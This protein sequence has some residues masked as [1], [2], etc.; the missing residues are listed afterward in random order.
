ME[1]IQLIF[2]VLFFAALAAFLLWK[3]RS[4]VLEWLIFPVVY[5]AM[6]RSLWGIRAMDSLAARM[7]PVLR[8]IGILAVIIGFIGMGLISYQLVK[9]LSDILFQKVSGSTVG[10][11]Q[12]FAQ[13]V[14]GTIFVPFIYFIVSIF[15]I[16]VLHE[17]AHGVM[18]RA[19]NCKVKSS[20]F[21]FFGILIPVIPAAFVEPSDKE[22]RRRPVM[23]QLSVLSAGAVT[24]VLFAAMVLLLLIY[25]IEPATKSLI[26]PLGVEVVKVE[27]GSPAF[28]S[29]LKPGELI[30][31]LNGAPVLDSKAMIGILKSMKPGDMLSIAASTT[32]HAAVL[33]ENPSKKGAP[34]LGFQVTNK[35]IVSESASQRYGQVFVEGFLWLSGLLFWVFNLSLGIGLFNLVPLGPIDGGKMLR[36]AF[37]TWFSDDT[38]HRLWLV[39]SVCFFSAILLNIGAAFFV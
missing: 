18:A 37:S 19:Y 15:I 14:P 25:A 11:V 21:A 34:Y 29:G 33:A 17:F 1:N 13:N 5:I 28:D 35:F 31:A 12:P 10:I 39:V 20:G 16:A 6:Y 26:T 2:A 24:N 4:V 23:A 27:K 3:R 22:M 36:L 7:K 38:A 8:V 30:T 32:S 9:N